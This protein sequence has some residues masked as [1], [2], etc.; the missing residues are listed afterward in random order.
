MEIQASRRTQPFTTVTS[1]T[2]DDVLD[3]SN[4]GKGLGGQRL[5]LG[6]DRGG[7]ESE[8]LAEPY[9]PARRAPPSAA[10][11]PEVGEQH[12]LED[13][14]PSMSSAT[15]E[16][17]GRQDRAH[18]GIVRARFKIGMMNLGYNIRRLV[19]LEWMAAAPA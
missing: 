9:P 15:A 12:A 6:P 7:P 19:Q 11:A 17:D 8:G 1:W 3:L 5:P 18:I 13:A 2:M 16:L 4:T 14:V 10:S